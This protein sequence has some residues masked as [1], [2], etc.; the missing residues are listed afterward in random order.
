MTV[1]ELRNK[2]TVAW[3][4]EY[5]KQGGSP[6]TFRKYVLDTYGIAYTLKKI[7][8]KTSR[9]DGFSIVDEK[10]YAWFLLRYS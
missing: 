10:K 7:T 3:F 2:L 1:S 8:E 9:M 6:H 4:E 5:K